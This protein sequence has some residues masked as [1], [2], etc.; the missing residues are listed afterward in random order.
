[1]MKRYSYKTLDFFM[2][3]T[4]VLPLNKFF[5]CFPEQ[6]SLIENVA[7]YSLESLMQ[8]S[9]KPEIREAILVASPSLYRSL[10]KID[11]FKNKSNVIEA[12]VVSSVMKYV[13]R[14]MSRPTPF[15][16][17]SGITVGRFS[18]KSQLDIKEIS[19]YRKRARPDMGWILK[20]IE[21]LENDPQIL[22]QLTIYPNALIYKQG[23]RAK[24]PFLTRYGKMKSGANDSISVKATIVFDWIMNYLSFPRKF[25][26]VLNQMELEFPGTD[27]EIINNYLQQLIKEEFLITEL[28][29]ST[30]DKDPFYHVFSLVNGLQGVNDIGKKLH[31]IHETIMLYNET[32][33]G[34]GIETFKQLSRMTNDFIPM[35]TPT[36]Q[37]DLSLADQS[38]RLNEH[39]R[40]DVEEAAYILNML[41]HYSEDHLKRYV[42]DFL[43]R[44]GDL[45]EIPVL[46]LIDDEL[47]LGAPATYR[48]PENR[49]NSYALKRRDSQ[50]KMKQEQL[51]M[52]LLVSAIHKGQH[53]VELDEHV[54]QQLEGSNDSQLPPL[55]SMELY[56]SLHTLDQNSLDHGEYKL[57]LAP[58]PGSNGAGKTFGRFLDIL[59]PNLQKDLTL[60]SKKEKDL[61]PDAMWAET[62]FLPT[63]GKSAN[64]MLTKNYRDH[65]IPLSHGGI[66]PNEQI[67]SMSDL[68]VGVKEGRLYI[69]SV[70]QNKEVIPTAG[71]MF[72]YHHAPNIYRFLMEVGL[73]RFD[74]WSAPDFGYLMNAPF[75]PRIQY[76]KIVLSPA[77]WNLRYPN[78]NLKESINADKLKNW[79][80]TFLREWNVPRYVYLIDSDNRILLDLDHPLHLSEL[81]KNLKTTRHINL[82]EHAGGFENL[83]IHRSDGC[84]AAEFVFP[85]IIDDAIPIK[86]SSSVFPFKK[87]SDRGVLG[88]DIYLPGNEWFYAKLYG[89]DS[90]QNEFLALYW[91][92]CVNEAKD[93]GL[94]EQAYFIR[95][96]DP[97]PHVRVRFKFKSNDK[98]QL[99]AQLFKKWSDEWFKDGYITKFTLETYEPEIERYG[100]TE[101]MKL[102]ESLFSEDSYVV[103]G[104]IRLNRFERREFEIEQI[105]VLSVIHLLTHL[106][107]NKTECFETLNEKFDVKDYLQDFRKVRNTYMDMLNVLFGLNTSQ[108]AASEKF[109]QELLPVFESR[110]NSSLKY[111]QKLEKHRSEVLLTNSTDDIVF[112]IIHMHLNRLIGT[113]RKLE[114]KIMILTRHAM[115]SLIQYHKRKRTENLSSV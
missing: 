25:S 64:V 97:D 82:I 107:Y 86:G 31:E 36:I 75:M 69:R 110:A 84:L 34:E 12:Q 66:T 105:G 57:V 33:V 29:P 7:S 102:A 77:K 8:L 68:V 9:R 22:E 98:S 58:N 71:H 95:Y 35:E 37:V 1:M 2:L 56:F 87:L 19:H 42:E 80:L 43:E 24:L 15:G 99:F 70:S 30:I 62:S 76:K 10:S 59:E 104:L 17:F 101:L 51:F 55:P 48:Y 109:T 92:E 5:S 65:E 85:L 93:I 46:E 44:Y 13:I 39:I 27:R 113:D 40:K 79:V 114:Q 6:H 83:P 14:M 20:L 108:T 60:I 96:A 49:K 11:E 47:G 3:R 103:A 94:I 67:I 112:S 74:Q 52:E 61:Y 115:N 106:G 26:K 21:Q 32:P 88:K 38:I 81:L 18:A 28:R 78:N 54:I 72:N 100:G 73:M 91:E 41:S 16:L 90:R 23:N 53:T 111:Y 89:L 50:G 63:S 4:P 45:K